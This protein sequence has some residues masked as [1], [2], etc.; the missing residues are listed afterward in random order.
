MR[1]SLLIF[2]VTFFLLTTLLLI[3]PVLPEKISGFIYR[4]FVYEK[5]SDI[6]KTSSKKDNI[7][8]L[9][10]YVSNDINS[11]YR[12]DLFLGVEKQFYKV[13]DKNS[14]NDLLRGVAWCDQQ[15]FVYMNLLN[16][17]GI[18]QTRLRD[19]NAHTYSEIL[20]DDK[21]IIADPFFGF[22]AVDK[23]GKNISIDELKEIDIEKS[24]ISD[25]LL[26]EENHIVSKNSK[27]KTL[28]K[29]FLNIYKKN[30][31]RWKEGASPEFKNLRSYDL[32]RSLLEEVVS[33]LYYIFGDF[34][35]FWYQD[36]YLDK[37]INGK[38]VDQ[39][40]YWITFFDQK[41]QKNDKAFQ[42]FYILRSYQLVE[43][44]DKVETYFLKLK[45]LFPDSIWTKEASYYLNEND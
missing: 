23:S 18:S 7:K 19:V 37:H 12:T 3:L 13:V 38:I 39:G 42:L 41:Y 24:I 20:I 16:K 32:T 17:L 36:T 22:L 35:F 34:Y 10:K 45:E 11:A 6:H 26:Y 28:I 14:H 44:F 30:E 43:R 40:E 1:K 9:F 21:W 8:N 5:I 27:D 15:A 31:V 2:L 25:E 4:E 33:F 29:D